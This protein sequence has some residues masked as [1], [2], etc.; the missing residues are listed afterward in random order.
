MSTAIANVQEKS[1]R[2]IV[3]LFLLTAIV[4]RVRCAELYGDLNRRA[5]AAR[6]REDAGVS[7]VELILITA[8]V[9]VIVGIAVVAIK[10]AVT[11]KSGDV[12]KCITGADTTNN[13]GCN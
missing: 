4:L 10:G 7:A 5:Q 6:E 11:T 9:I 8:A 13:G 1:R 12:S 3:E 2:P